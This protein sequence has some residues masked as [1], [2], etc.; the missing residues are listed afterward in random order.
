MVL[1]E[2]A[3]A[4]ERKTLEKFEN[5]RD[6]LKENFR[7]TD[8]EE[9]DECLL[10][11]TRRAHRRYRRARQMLILSIIVAIFVLIAAIWCLVQIYHQQHLPKWAIFVVLVFFFIP[12]FS[13]PI[14]LSIIIYYFLTQNDRIRSSSSDTYVLQND[15]PQQIFIQH[16]HIVSRIS[17]MPQQM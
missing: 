3:Y 4:N 9:M 14:Q 2:Y 17:P 5:A 7:M 6:K 10:D 13:T 15:N 12:Y 11:D 16:P 8:G 1:I